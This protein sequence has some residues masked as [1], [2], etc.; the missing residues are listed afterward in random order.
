MKNASFSSTSVGNPSACASLTA[1][2]IAALVCSLSC[3]AS[4]R[5]KRACLLLSFLICFLNAGSVL[6]T[7]SQ[8]QYGLY[9][10]TP[11]HHLEPNIVQ[12]LTILPRKEETGAH[13]CG[14][15]R[16]RMLRRMRLARVHTVVNL[17]TS[18]STY[19]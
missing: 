5:A 9:H 19:Q 7:T 14:Q 17:T 1:L 11:R 8:N 16:M 4:S 18:S 10:A 15:S 6:P 13:F 12:Q 2:F 3:S